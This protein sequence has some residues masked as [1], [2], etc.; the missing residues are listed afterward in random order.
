MK[1]SLLLLVL[2]ILPALRPAAVCGQVVPVKRTQVRNVYGGASLGNDRWRHVPVNA[3]K[4]IDTE[5]PELRTKRD[6][7]WLRAF[8]K[9]G[10]VPPEGLAFVTPEVLNIP[11]SVWIVAKFESYR[12]FET[13]KRTATY[14]EITL[15]VKQEIANRGRSIPAGTLIET[16]MP[17]G[18]LREASGSV[19]DY[20]AER[21]AFSLQ[22]D[23]TYLLLVVFDPNLNLYSIRRQWDATFGR[24]IPEGKDEAYHARY[25]SPVIAGKELADAVA[26]IRNR[27]G[28]NDAC[29]APPLLVTK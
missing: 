17:G 4:Q 7:A 13:S 11:D 2:I 26:A 6:Q 14:T 15:R 10:V 28:E 21:K 3:Q 1:V 22:P 18:A 24:L 9:P 19:F 23:H 8:P 29:G 5:S 25:C 20:P 27:T 12:I 16:W